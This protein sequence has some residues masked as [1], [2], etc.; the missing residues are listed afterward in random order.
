MESNN[1][2][3]ARTYNNSSEDKI[4]FLGLSRAWLREVKKTKGF[5]A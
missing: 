5:S 2:V 3:V 4:L 1:A